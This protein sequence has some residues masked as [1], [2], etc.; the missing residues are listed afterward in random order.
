V[1]AGLADHVTE[2]T[3]FNNPD[4][5]LDDFYEGMTIG[6][7]WGYTTE[8]LFQSEE[9]IANHADQSRYPSN[10]TGEDRVGDIKLRDIDGNGEVGPGALTVDNPGD[11]RVIGNT[12]PR[13]R[14]NFGF[15]VQYRNVYVASLLE[16]VAKQDWLPS[17]EQNSFFGQYNRPYNQSPSWHFDEGMAWSEDNPEAFLPRKSGYQALGSGRRM[18][19]P[20]TRY[21]MN[22]AR[23]RLKNLQ[24]GYEIPRRL[25]GSFGARSASIYFSGDNLWQWGPVLDKV[26]NIDIQREQSAADVFHGG[27]APGHNYPFLTSYTLGVNLTF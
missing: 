23:V 20:Q 14:F 1:E 17:A 21:L 11:L 13:Y 4:R 22:G 15:D 26:R 5:F 9:E 25:I 6:E 2:I 3:R 10:G 7:V 19:V 8:G 12:E 18:G 24:V 16:G 27:G